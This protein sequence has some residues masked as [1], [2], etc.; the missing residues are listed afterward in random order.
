MKKIEKSVEKYSLARLCRLICGADDAQR[1]ESLLDRDCGITVL[2]D[3]GTEIVNNSLV[4]EE[5]AA[6]E[7]LRLAISDG[8]A[9][10]KISFLLHIASA[11]LPERQ[12]IGVKGNAS[13]LAGQRDLGTDTGVRAGRTREGR[14]RARFEGQG[15]N[16][17][18]LALDIV[19]AEAHMRG[20]RLRLAHKMKHQIDGMYRLIHEG[21]SAVHLPRASPTAVCGVISII[22]M[23]LYSKGAK[24]DLAESAVRESLIYGI[25]T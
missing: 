1:K 6:A 22:A 17:Q 2:E 10:E 25:E 9:C 24:M 21:A 7:L 14:N 12:L 11:K 3:R 19:S 20:D 13:I 8:I 23:P 15:R 4:T 5:S 18:I 16:R